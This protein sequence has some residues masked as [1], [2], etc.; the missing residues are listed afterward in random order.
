MTYENVSAGDFTTYRNIQCID[1]TANYQRITIT[2]S[3]I[4]QGSNK[5][6]SYSIWL[7][8]T[9]SSPSNQRGIS[10]GNNSNGTELCSPNNYGWVIQAGGNG[11]D[12]NTGVEMT[13][14]KWYHFVQNYFEDGTLELWLNGVKIYSGA[15][16][17]FNITGTGMRIGAP[18]NSRFLN[19]Y[20]GYAAAARLWNRALN[21]NEIAALAAEFTP[22]T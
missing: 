3:S 19:Y 18:S 11:H 5:P 17:M 4:N 12:F 2:E 13:S 15:T 20:K 8:M 14:G 21:K 22:T 1:L 7:A 9:A 6:R 16:F 10:L